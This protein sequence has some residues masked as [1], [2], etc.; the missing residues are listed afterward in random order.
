MNGQHPPGHPDPVARAPL[1]ALLAASG[2]SRQARPSSVRY[3]RPDSP[4]RGPDANSIF[5]DRHD[6]SADQIVTMSVNGLKDHREL[7]VDRVGHE[8]KQASMLPAISNDQV[9][10][11]FVECDKNLAV[12]MSMGQNR[13]VSGIRRPI[14]HAL[15]IVTCLAQANRGRRPYRRIDK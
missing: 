7:T 3:L 15:D 4:L 14:A 9:A 10:E 13:Q 5:L 12:S 11:L 1:F 2:Y 8:T 6:R